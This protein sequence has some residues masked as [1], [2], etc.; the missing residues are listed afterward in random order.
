MWLAV[1]TPGRLG[2]WHVAVP[3]RPLAILA[4]GWEL[5]LFTAGVTAESVPEPRVVS[6]VAARA[7]HG[8]WL[9][10]RTSGQCRQHLERLF[11]LLSVPH[12]QLFF[13]FEDVR[14]GAQ[15]GGQGRPWGPILGSPQASLGRQVVMSSFPEN[16]WG[17][18]SGLSRR[19]LASRGSQM[20]GQGLHPGL[21]PC[22]WNVGECG[23]RGSEIQG[24]L[25]SEPGA[26]LL[27][28]PASGPWQRLS[29]CAFGARA[30]NEIWPL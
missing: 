15:E 9:C 19:S 6:A 29:F 21:Q 10:S 1:P 12:V 30:W 2:A 22:C 20:P 28:C 8:Q 26:L 11:S 17:T 13:L 5:A 4:V 14:G 3:S 25:V 7:L 16:T 23:G 24:P 27:P 18:A